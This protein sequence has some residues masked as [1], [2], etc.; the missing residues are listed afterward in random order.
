M[1]HTVHSLPP[2]SFHITK[3]FQTLIWPVTL[4]GI[5]GLL[6]ASPAS[7]EDAAFRIRFGFKDQAPA[8]WEGSVSIPE[9]KCPSRFRRRL[10]I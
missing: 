3:S 6:A 9:W 10:A 5:L 7:A 1:K 4:A 2:S 8:N